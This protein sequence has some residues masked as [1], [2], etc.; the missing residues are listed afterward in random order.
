VI[1]SLLLTLGAGG[2]A[3]VAYYMA[4]AA[5]GTHRYVVPRAQL[6]ATITRLEARDDERVCKL[7]A[8]SAELD[9]TYAE[10]HAA[11]TGLEETRHHAADLARQTADYQQLRAEVQRLQAQL[12]NATAVRPLLP[13]RPATGDDASALDDAVQEFTDTTATSWRASA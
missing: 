3:A 13:A 9:G 11:L 12:A 1:S 4:P 7:L 8:L 5:R 6:R 2:T 10:L